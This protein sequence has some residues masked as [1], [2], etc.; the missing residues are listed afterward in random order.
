MD[1]KILNKIR[2]LMFYDNSKPLNEQKTNPVAPSNINKV[3]KDNEVYD[4]NTKGMVPITVKN[5]E[6]RGTPF[7][8]NPDEYPEYLKKINDIKQEFFPY[9]PNY[10]IALDNLKKQYYHPDWYKGISKDDFNSYQTQSKDIEFEKYKNAE[11]IKKDLTPYYKYNP[12]MSDRLDA[13]NNNNIDNVT[14]KV[15][16]RSNTNYDT[17]KILLDILYEYDP[18]SLEEFEKLNQTNLEKFWDDYNFI[19]ELAGWF[20]LDYISAGLAAEVGGLRQG[21]LIQKIVKNFGKINNKAKVAKLITLSSRVGVPILAGTAITL[22]EGELNF[23]GAIYFMMAILP[24]AHTYF[25]LAKTNKIIS[26]GVLSKIMGKNLS[27]P[28]VLKEVIKSLNNAEKSLLRDVLAIPTSK[29]LSGVKSL[30]KDLSKKTVKNILSTNFP[31]NAIKT[32]IGKKLVNGAGK[33]LFRFSVDLTAMFIIDKILYDNF[34]DYAKKNKIREE[35]L[36]YAEIYKSDKDNL[37]KAA[38]KLNIVLKDK[39][40]P[41]DMKEIFKPG[42]VDFKTPEGKKLLKEYVKQFG[43]EEYFE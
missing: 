20:V 38:I 26:D 23:H 15:I 28:K 17:K 4:L 24:Y 22:N 21:F 3:D 40:K 41:I 37:I 18:Y 14:N 30:L 6:T 31:S 36:K 13:I 10:Q 29:Q 33:L 39:D 32:T 7:G 43:L 11:K 1:K 16:S 27:D 5:V 2:L 34:F 9:E 8:F 25:G 35:F 42:G 19:I 12:G